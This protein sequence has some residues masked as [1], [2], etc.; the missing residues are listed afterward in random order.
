VDQIN[1]RGG[2]VMKYYKFVTYLCLS[3]SFLQSQEIIRSQF[4][5]VGFQAFDA[6]EPITSFSTLGPDYDGYVY[7]VAHTLSGQEFTFLRSKW[8]GIQFQGF[9]STP[10]D[11]I[12]GFSTYGP[13]YDGYVYLVA[14]TCQGDSQYIMRSK[15][16]QIEIQDFLALT[17]YGVSGFDVLEAG[18]YVTLSC[19]TSYVGIEENRTPISLPKRLQIFSISPNP[20]SKFIILK[21]A[22]PEKDRVYIKL[23]DITGRALG[24]LYDKVVDPGIYSQT[25][26]FSIFQ[27]LKNGVYFIKIATSKNSIVKKITILGR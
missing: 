27:G 13:D 23:Y 9:N 6:G 10:G 15:W 25:Y 19:L 21:Y 4:E 1:N 11:Y 24:V 2:G 3:F 17:N 12:T 14:H 22:V 5:G 26:D 8:Q 18:G 16:Q 7:L 20:A